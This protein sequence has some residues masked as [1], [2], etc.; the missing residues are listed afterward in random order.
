MPLLSLFH[1]P[2]PYL[3]NFLRDLSFAVF[4]DINEPVTKKLASSLF[5]RARLFSE[6]CDP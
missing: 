3:Y 6:S 1:P 2:L 5:L 4:E